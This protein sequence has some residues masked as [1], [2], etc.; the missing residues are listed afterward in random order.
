MSVVLTSDEVYQTFYDDYQTMKAFLHSHSYTGNTLACRV[1]LEVLRIFEE[2]NVLEENQEKSAYMRELASQMF[3]DLPYVGEYRQT[4]MVGAVE[5]VKDKATKESFPS[6]ERIGYQIYQIALEKGLLLRPLGN[7]LYFMPPYVIS[8]EE[9]KMMIE[10]ANEAI[11]QFFEKSHFHK[12][13]AL[14]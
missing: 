4:G 6:Q 12:V 9:I 13:D 11:G 14:V 5:L 3:G 8:K 2:E 7:I 1:A 10:T